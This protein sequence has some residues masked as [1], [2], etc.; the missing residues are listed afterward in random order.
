VQHDFA[1]QIH[2]R[3]HFDLRRGLRHDNDRRHTAAL[4]GKRYALCMI[5]A[6]AQITPRLAADSDRC[7]T[8]L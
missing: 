5:T 8:L 2:D 7:A 4:G 6:D 1:A 3:L